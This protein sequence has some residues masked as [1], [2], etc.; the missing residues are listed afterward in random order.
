MGF[1]RPPCARGPVFSTPSTPD[2]TCVDDTGTRPPPACDFRV[3]PRTPGSVARLGAEEICGP[4][5]HRAGNH[6][7]DACRRRRTAACAGIRRP[8]APSHAS[9]HLGPCPH[10]VIRSVVPL[11]SF[12]HSAGRALVRSSAHSNIRPSAHRSFARTLALSYVAR[13][14]R[15]SPARFSCLVSFLL[16]LARSLWYQCVRSL[17]RSLARS[18]AR[19][20]AHS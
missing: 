11:P 1:V 18:F 20:F 19:S 3:P 13:L 15:S 2:I 5:S 6:R 8:R 12:A 16:S 10:L 7:G 4:R 17:A 14:V 9:L